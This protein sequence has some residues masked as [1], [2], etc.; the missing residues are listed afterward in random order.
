MDWNC[1]AQLPSPPSLHSSS[2]VEVYPPT[3][4]GVSER[5]VV[6]NRCLRRGGVSVALVHAVRPADELLR[7]PR[8]EERERLLLDLSV[9]NVHARSKKA[10]HRFVSSARSH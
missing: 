8:A 3:A 7:G 5:G 2:T 10:W 9:L 1:S 4:L 6:L